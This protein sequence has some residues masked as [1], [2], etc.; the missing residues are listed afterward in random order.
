MPE[1]E[2]GI[3]QKHLMQFL[4][5]EVFSTIT[6]D[7]ILRIKAPN[8]WE[9]KGKE[10]PTETIMQLKEQAKAFSN[11]LL[12]KVLKSELQWHA[13][14]NL[15]EDGKTASDVRAAQLL[16]YLT[17]VLDTKLKKMSD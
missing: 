7:D 9:W 3:L 11:S 6:V 8:V 17:T 16:G 5:R 2:Q 10:V 4:V 15:L 13:A 1:E 14:K 12:W